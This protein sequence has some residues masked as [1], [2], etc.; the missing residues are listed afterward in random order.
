MANKKL[1]IDGVEYKVSN[2]VPLN[3]TEGAGI[4]R[5]SAIKR[6]KV[7]EH[8]VTSPKIAKSI[9]GWAKLNKIGLALRAEGSSTRIHR[10]PVKGGKK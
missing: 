3:K 1:V 2:N 4:H 6:L 8:I 10:V 5:Y 7:G 9:Y